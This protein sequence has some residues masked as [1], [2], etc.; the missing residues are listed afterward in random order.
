TPPGVPTERASGNSPSSSPASATT[1]HSSPLAMWIV[2]S[3][4]PL[5]RHVRRALIRRCHQ[6]DLREIARERRRLLLRVGP[7]PGAHELRPSAGPG[8]Q[9]IAV[10]LPVHSLRPFVSEIALVACVFD[11]MLQRRRGIRPSPP[12]P[13]PGEERGNVLECRP[14]IG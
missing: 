9:L 4:T 1:C 6:C 2:I 12:V 3:V 7:I 13:Q 8:N 10:V 14:H 11:D 5:R